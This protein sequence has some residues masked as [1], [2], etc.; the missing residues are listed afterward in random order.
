MTVIDANSHLGWDRAVRMDRDNVRIVIE[1]E[2]GEPLSGAAGRDGDPPVRFDGML[3]F[4]ALFEQ[5]RAD[6]NAAPGERD[7]G[8]RSM[9]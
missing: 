6:C 1:I 4:L 8:K 5:L 9:S 2:Q 7:S 3:G